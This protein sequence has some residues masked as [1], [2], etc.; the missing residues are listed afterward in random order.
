[1]YS[2]SS[3]VLALCMVAAMAS[4]VP[5]SAASDDAEAGVGVDLQARLTEFV[6]LVPGGAAAITVHDGITTTAVAGIADAGGTP[7]TIDTSFLAG[8]VI[9]PID[10]ALVLQLVDEGV[11][12]LDEPVATYL[13]DDPIN[14]EATVRSL[15][16]HLDGVPDVSGT[17]IDRSLEDASHRWTDDEMVGLIDATTAGSVG[18]FTPPNYTNTL[19]VRRLIAAA[20]GTDYATALESRIATPLGLTSTAPADGVDVPPGLAAGWLL[21]LG[22][23]GDHAASGSAIRTIA[24]GATTVGDVAVFLSALMEGRILS[25]EAIATMFDEDVARSGYGFERHE[26]YLGDLGELGERYFVTGGGVPSGFSVAAAVA[27]STGDLVVVL[28]NNIDLDSIDFLR[29]TLSGW[30]AE[31]PTVTTYQAIESGGTSH[32]FVNITCDYGQRTVRDLP[33]CHADEEGLYLTVVSPGQR[34]GA[35]DGF[36]VVEGVAVIDPVDGS[37]AYSGQMAFAGSVEG[38]GT[39][40]VFFDVEGEGYT[41]AGG[42][43][44]FTSNSFTVTPGGTLDLAGTIDEAGTEV[45]QGDGTVTLEY[46]ASYS[47]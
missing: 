9:S 4:A 3:L 31:S 35:F 14:A 38:C 28:A 5:V 40:T 37:F 21:E 11:L 26:E 10:A 13:P 1:M 34:T 12:E 33:E 15:M 24:P 46:R 19:I 23:T 16:T 22:Q 30:A 39:G 25:S 45:P 29:D 6:G 17:L 2:K 44:T 43:T 42:V 47:C 18:T 41:D 36:Q 7:I 8:P 32:E 20:S 27:P